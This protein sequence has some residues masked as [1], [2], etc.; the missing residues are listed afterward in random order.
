[1]RTQKYEL[2]KNRAERRDK[3][4]RGAVDKFVLEMEDVGKEIKKIRI[5]HDNQ[6]LSA[7]WHVDKVE[8]R[9]LKS[10]GKGSRIFVFECNRWLARDE[11]DKA[12][13][14]DLVA[15]KLIDE[16]FENGEIKSKE[17]DIRDQLES[18]WKF[19]LIK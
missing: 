15:S 2:C 10:S 13:E 3:F 1:M 4:K 8:I 5:G 16:K 17:K 7:G 18:N 6:G 11:D 12:I 9:R 14:R 19:I